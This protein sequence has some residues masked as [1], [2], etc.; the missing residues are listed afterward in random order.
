MV[1]AAVT[2]S[3]PRAAAL[4]AANQPSPPPVPI[5]ALIDTGAS[6]TC[7]D[8][9]VLLSLQLTPTGTVS[10]ATPSTGTVPFVAP[11]Y[12][13]AIVIP[14]GPG[15][16]P[17]IIPAVAVLATELLAPQGFHALIGRD[18]LARCILHYNGSTGL[19]TIAF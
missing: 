18:I 2:V 19:F 6:G 11:Q 8:P 9:S 7:V 15:D 13:V 4:K 12:D 3:E 14:G 1:N 5:R 17:L 10:V 16:T